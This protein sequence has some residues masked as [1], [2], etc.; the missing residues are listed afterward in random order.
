MRKLI[1][2][3]MLSADGFFCGPNGEI[4]WHNVDAEFNAFA[5]D[6]LNS[7]DT[8]V[9]GRV[10]YDLMAS[11]WPKPEAL[12]DDPMIAEKMNSL[13][14][15]VFSKTKDSLAWNN[16]TVMNEIRVDEIQA[17]KQL[18]GKDIIIYGSGM[19]V[20]QMTQLGLIDEFRF[21]IN[22]IILGKGRTL[23]TPLE[24]RQKLKLLETKTFASGNVLCRYQ[25]V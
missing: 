24:A 14:K 18:P 25:P 4:D 11:Y 17:M 8:L 6:V 7:V 15:I 19:I 5:I 12:K 16:S 10:T 23:F 3:E 2:Q 20:A 1:V 22:P 9:F 13:P 21:I